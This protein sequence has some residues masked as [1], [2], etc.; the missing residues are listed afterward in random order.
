[1][2]NGSIQNFLVVDVRYDFDRHIDFVDGK[3][4]EIIPDED[5][6]DL[7]KEEKEKIRKY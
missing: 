5:Y 1:M 4:V 6:A 3:D 7:T 2:E